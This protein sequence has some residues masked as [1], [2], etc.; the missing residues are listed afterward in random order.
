MGPLM[1]A[2]VNKD[3][4]TVIFLLN[5]GFDVNAQ[6]NV[7]RTALM[8]CECPKIGLKLIKR[9]A[10]IYHKNT[11]GWTALNYTVHKKINGMILLLRQHMENTPKNS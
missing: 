4:D 9:G 10:D 8:Y 11:N 3:M 6:D 2:V 7:G 1:Y 5:N